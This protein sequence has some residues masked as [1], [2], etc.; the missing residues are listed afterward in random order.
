GRGRR[1][2]G[3]GAG[4][5]VHGHAAADA[6]D[7]GGHRRGQPLHRPGRAGRPPPGP[8]PAQPGRRP[9]G[10]RR[11]GRHDRRG[12]P[13]HGRERPSPPPGPQSDAHGL[14]RGQERHRPG[15]RRDPRGL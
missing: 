6:A 1:R 7:A 13:P 8:E 9:G 12:R 14:H 10:H 3:R 2:D 15:R 11:L 5:R 4:G